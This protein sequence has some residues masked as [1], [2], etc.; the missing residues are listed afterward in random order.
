MSRKGRPNKLT[1]AVKDRI[2]QA[3]NVVNGPHNSGLIKLAAEHPAIFYSLVAK[4]VPV[5]ATVALTVVALDLGQAIRDNQ[6]TLDRLNTSTIDVTPSKPA[7]PLVT[8]EK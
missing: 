8:E 7:T 4:L 3:F 1:A 6:K 2:E 5:Q